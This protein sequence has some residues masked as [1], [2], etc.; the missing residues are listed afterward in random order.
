MGSNVVWSEEEEIGYNS[1]IRSS[2][3]EKA[4]LLK[5]NRYEAHGILMSGNREY[6]LLLVYLSSI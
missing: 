1:L 4:Q 5:D 6:I 3:Y 2:I